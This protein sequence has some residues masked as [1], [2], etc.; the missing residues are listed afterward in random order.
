MRMSTPP[1]DAITENALFDR[2]YE[3]L[4]RRPDQANRIHETD[5]E[6]VPIDGTDLL[7]ALT[8]DTVAEEIKEGVYTE[9]ETIGWMGA[10]VALSDLAGVGAAPLGIVTSVTLPHG[11]DPS[12]QEGVARGLDA[13][14]RAADTFILGG[15]TNFAADPSITGCAAGIVAR[16]ELLTRTGC[17][18]GDIVFASGPLGAGAA[19]A[20]RAVV[21][22]PA[23]LY[24]ESDYRPHA[25][26]AEARTLPGYA[27]ACMDTS[28]GLLSTL[29]QLM[30]LNGVG[31]LIETPPLE[32]LEP[33]T[34]TVCEMLG[35]PPLAMLGALHGEFEL[36]FTVPDARCADFD[37]LARQSG[38]APL[39][40]G[41]VIETPAVYVAGKP[42]RE[43]DTT[44][45][46]NLLDNVEGDLIRYLTEMVHIV[47]A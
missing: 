12:F 40:V 37:A 25:R 3:V 7:L 13:A 36:I 18:A 24:V 17:L 34:R 29:D 9:P 1:L 10:T 5:A 22:L 6:L 28:D 15:D 8:V 31:F 27:T 46:R 19:A 35:V 26:I 45:V 32:L 21:G 14:C 33:R 42:A 39:R 4:A 20:A 11:G 30:R 23:E 38:F 43:V 47:E 41:R 44:R 2:W 16:S